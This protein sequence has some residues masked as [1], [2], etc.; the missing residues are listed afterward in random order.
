MIQRILNWFIPQTVEGVDVSRWQKGLALSGI[1][2]NHGIRFAFIKASEGVGYSDPLAYE[3]ASNAKNA[4]MLVSY[5][6][7]A[8]PKPSE[9]DPLQ[10]ADYFV[11]VVDGLPRNDLP[12]VLDIEKKA[13]GMTPQQVTDW[14]RAFLRRVEFLTGTKPILYTYSSFGRSNFT[15][16]HDLGQY[17]LWIAHYGVDAP[18]M[19]H[20]WDDYTIWQYTSTGRISGYDKNIDLNKARR[21]LLTMV[22]K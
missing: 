17:P 9:A 2:R 21:S 7:F 16:D 4:G 8:T 6:H 3:H 1:H 5:Y 13:D 11:N 19:I 10:E 14:A 18:R 15:K 20:G 12:L 22:R